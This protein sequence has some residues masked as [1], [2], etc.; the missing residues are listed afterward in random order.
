MPP[1]R[2]IITMDGPSGCGK[3]TTAR[4]LADALDWLYLDTGAM[5]RAVAWQSLQ[6][7]VASTD[8]AALGR[9]AR[10]TRVTLRQDARRRLHVAA[11]GR[12]VTRAI[13]T[14]AV[15]A[16]AS[17]IAVIPAVR[18]ALVAAQQRI[19]RQGRL[20]AEGRDTGTVVF[21]DAALK[22]FLT[23]SVTVRARRR[24]RELRAAGSTIS[25][26]QVVR[27]QRARDRRDAR[28]AVAPLRR[29]PEATVI[30]TSRQ[31]PEQTVQT[32]LGLLKHY[33]SAL[34][35]GARE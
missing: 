31:T 33:P 30:D 1:R 2:P 26:V 4:A 13:R 16:R 6:D 5:Y 24:W 27:D 25:L 8:A 9:L 32:I 12:D 22:I 11:N 3:S 10:Q 7:G 14:A 19:G 17:E 34:Q 23:A 35:S 15:S 28:R 21:P 20:V 18:R 29:A